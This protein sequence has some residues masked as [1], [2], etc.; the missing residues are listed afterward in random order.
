MEST[1]NI[2]DRIL[3]NKVSYSV[4]EVARGDLVVFERG[5][6]VEGD[7]DELI[8]RA[9]ALPGETVELRDDGQLYIWGP[10]EGPE[11]AFVLNEPY[12]PDDYAF[13][14]PSASDL[15]EVDIW[16]ERC[17]NQPREIGRC[18]LDGQSYFM[19]GDNRGGSTDSRVFGPVP[20]ENIVGKAFLRIWPLGEFGGL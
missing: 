12:L 8:K 1:I 16:D 7:T 18:T 13:P 15:V 17:A 3:V 19:M 11:D 6:L 14:G 20:S 10:G 2:G 5:T 9:I 4:G